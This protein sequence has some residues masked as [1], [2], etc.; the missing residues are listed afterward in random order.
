[1]LSVIDIATVNDA[2]KLPVDSC[3][4][5]NAEN[6][7]RKTEGRFIR[8]ALEFPKVIMPPRAFPKRESRASP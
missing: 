1:M 5:S 3:E 6:L 2:G 7:F 8:P 4:S